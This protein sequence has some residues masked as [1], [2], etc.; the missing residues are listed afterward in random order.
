MHTTDHYALGHGDGVDLVELPYGD[1]KLSM[2]VV[3]PKAKDGLAVVEKKIAGGAL[4]GWLKTL[5]GQRVEVTLPRFKMG[6]S[7]EL[8]EVLKKL[9]MPLPFIFP[10]ADFSGIDGTKLLYIGAVIHQ[11]VVDVDE[12]GTE[13]AAATAVLMA[14]GGM[15]AQP[16]AFRADHPFVFLIRDRETNTILFIGRLADPTK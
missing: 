13:A 10:G 14:A 2:V 4:G 7:F 16:V 12:H 8:A 6:A 9:D 5:S 15:P 3:L 11:A 1:G